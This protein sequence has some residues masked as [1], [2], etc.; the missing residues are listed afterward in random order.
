[1]LTL[2][3]VL[4]P[5]PV[6]FHVGSQALYWYGFAY[7][8]GFAVMWLWLSSR[9]ERLGWAEAHVVD[10]CIVLVAGVIVGGRILDVTL[11]EWEWY[12]GRAWEIPMLWKGG[13]ASHGVLLGGV[14]AAILVAKRTRTPVFVLLDELACPAAIVLGLGRIGNLIEG[15]VIGTPTNMPWGVEI[16]GVHGFRHP[17]SLYDGLKNLVLVPMLLAVMRRRPAGTGIATGVFSL[18]YGGLRFLAD[19]FRDYESSLFGMGAGQ[20]F[21]LAM[22]AI[23]IAILVARRHAR[24]LRI[25]PLSGGPAPLWRKA[26]LVG[27]MLVPLGIPTSWTTSYIELKREAGAFSRGSAEA[28]I[29]CSGPDCTTVHRLARGL[30]YLGPSRANRPG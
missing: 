25:E 17:V 5:N 14:A 2:G 15:G 29:A 20:W 8:F 22:A 27:L 4:A 3:I 26:F 23:G 30:V 18:G 19:Q 28:L 13:M 11:Y 16:P 7:T 6:M 10:A 9:R 21:N 12:R 1:M 24:I